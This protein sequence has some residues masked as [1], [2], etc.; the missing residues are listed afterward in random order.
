[1]NKS[2]KSKTKKESA[3]E[4]IWKTHTERGDY[5]PHQV[6]RI[7]CAINQEAGEKVAAYLKQIGVDSYVENGR[8]I[9]EH[10]KP[11]SFGLPGKVIQLQS[12]I[13]SVFRFTVP[14]KYAR[15]VMESVTEL[16]ELD[17]PG[18][19]TIF[20]QE[21]IEF[22]K[23]PPNI[24][25]E[26]ADSHTKKEFHF[27]SN[28]SYVTCVLTKAGSGEQLARTALELGICVPLIT[29]GTGND[30]RDQL[31]LIRIT[32]PPEKEVVHLVMPEQ[33]S[34]SI[35]QLLAEESKLDRPGRGHIHQTPVSL[36]L[37]DT[38]M[39][40]GHQNYPASID[41]IIAAIDTLKHGTNWRKRLDTDNQNS[42]KSFLPRH[43]CEISIITEEEKIDEI[44]EACIRIGAT[45]AVTSRVSTITQ[46][47]KAE[48]LNGLIR[49]EISVPAEIADKVVDTLLHIST[50]KD[51]ATDKVQLL[52]APLKK[53]TE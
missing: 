41:Q 48:E 5:N 16:A 14:R 20:S 17:V 36:G 38:R 24:Q 1:M 26:E 53:S 46:D 9:R 42:N 31:G 23:E 21:L 45:G 29:F 44:T 34:D 30:I 32:I 33:D 47:E 6:S 11:K 50:I 4:L 10:I 40:I 18:R 39:K 51:K 27:L 12:T 28:L 43:N 15:Q 19:G 8:T 49:N 37:I 35:I 25:M 7:T 3:S 52:E 2:D 22:S 13:V